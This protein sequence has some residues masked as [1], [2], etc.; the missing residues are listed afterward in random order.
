MMSAPESPHVVLAR[1]EADW[2]CYTEEGT[3]DADSDVRLAGMGQ[4]EPAGSNNQ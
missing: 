1:V 4:E 3:A 2:Q